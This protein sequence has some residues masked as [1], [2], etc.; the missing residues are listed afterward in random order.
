MLFVLPS[1]FLCLRTHRKKMAAMEGKMRTRVMFV[2]R[3]CVAC[4]GASPFRELEPGS[5]H[6]S[7]PP[8]TPPSSVCQAGNGMPATGVTEC[9]SAVVGAQHVICKPVCH[10]PTTQESDKFLVSKMRLAACL[11]LVAC[12]TW[13]PA[14]LGRTKQAHSHH[15]S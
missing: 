7:Q 11:F 3:K 6:R 10:Q 9:R 12:W 8:S 5:R 13:G 15:V 14:M 1:S 4:H 2:S